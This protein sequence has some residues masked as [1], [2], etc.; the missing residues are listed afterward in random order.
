MLGQ[1]ASYSLFLSWGSRCWDRFAIYSFAKLWVPA[2][3][4]LIMQPL[5]GSLLASMG[6]TVGHVR[7]HF[8]V[9]FVDSRFLG[10]VF[11][12]I[13]FLGNENGF[14]KIGPEWI[15]FPFTHL[16]SLNI[17]RQFW[18]QCTVSPISSGGD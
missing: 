1:I 2:E 4:R 13:F 17:L 15:P 8:R 18:A 7:R 14:E 6:G 3:T 9:L 16:L 12:S 5:A 10:R 11:K